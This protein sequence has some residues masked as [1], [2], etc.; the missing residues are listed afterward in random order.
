M[1]G[2]DVCILWLIRIRG[3]RGTG[4]DV[5]LDVTINP[6]WLFMECKHRI[7]MGVPFALFGLVRSSWIH[8]GS[9]L[10]TVTLIGPVRTE[11]SV[12]E[13]I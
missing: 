3:L 8:A 4:R 9:L 6:P 2:R 7:D 13:G 10:T 1:K 12:F 11:V 5:M